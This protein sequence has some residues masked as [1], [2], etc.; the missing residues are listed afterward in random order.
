MDIAQHLNR[1]EIDSV[2]S[3]LHNVSA[4]SVNISHYWWEGGGGVRVALPQHYA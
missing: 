3:V 4:W 1:S 2:G